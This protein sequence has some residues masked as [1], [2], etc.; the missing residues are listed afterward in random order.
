MPSARLVTT[1][2]NLLIAGTAGIKAVDLENHAGCRGLGG[3][4]QIKFQ[5]AVTN[6]TTQINAR[7]G[8]EKEHSVGAVVAELNVHRHTDIGIA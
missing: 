3:Q 7:R 2:V 6:K 5:L 8:R 1:Q 4:A